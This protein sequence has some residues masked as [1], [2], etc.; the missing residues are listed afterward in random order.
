MYKIEYKRSLLLRKNNGIKVQQST[1]FE[2]R[3]GGLWFCTDR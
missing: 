1:V 3:A 2:N